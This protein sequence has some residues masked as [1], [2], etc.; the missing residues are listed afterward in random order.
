MTKPSSPDMPAAATKNPGDEATPGTEQTGEN[1][2][3]ACHGSGRMPDD[4]MC[5]NCGGSGIVIVTV[6]DA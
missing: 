6:G 3:P 4:A 5:T 2:C 1:T